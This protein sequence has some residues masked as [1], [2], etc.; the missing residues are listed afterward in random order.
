MFLNPSLKKKRGGG[1]VSGQLSWYRNALSRRIKEKC[2]ED[3][4]LYFLLLFSYYLLFLRIRAFYNPESLKQYFHF[5]K[6]SCISFRCKLRFKNPRVG[7][8]ASQLYYLG[9][10]KTLHCFFPPFFRVLQK[11]FQ[12]LSQLFGCTYLS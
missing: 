6:L 9:V 4:L 7:N 12:K 10:S 11:L 2:I 8:I 1:Y 3:I 5:V